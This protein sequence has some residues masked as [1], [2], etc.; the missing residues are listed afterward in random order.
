M[1]CAPEHA[2]FRR[3]RRFNTLSSDWRSARWRGG[4]YDAGRREPFK[5]AYG[6]LALPETTIIVT[7]SGSTSHTACE[8]SAGG[9]YIGRDFPGAV[10]IVPAKMKRA[11]HLRDGGFDWASVT[12]SNE[13]LESCTPGAGALSDLPAVHNQ[14]DPLISELVAMLHRHERQVGLD[15][16]LGE[17]VAHVLCRH[18]VKTYA[19]QP[20]ASCGQKN[21]LPGF[22]LRR[23]TN[24]IEDHLAE[25]IELASLANLA[26]LS[27]SHFSRSFKAATGTTPYA[28][29]TERR[30]ARARML[31]QE[32]TLPIGSVALECGFNNPSR[33]AEVFRRH[34]GLG[35]RDYAR[36]TNGF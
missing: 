35:P 25:R 8:D 19:M 18:L 10:S 26:G 28:Y 16:I 7:L 36:Q 29:V 3:A 5:D 6:E 34:V 20:L 22:M 2:N 4:A 33:F 15:P 12:L 17:S 24:Y 27:A 32:N 11:V 14:R 23:V 9:R 13:A 30:I 1:E 31:L 21:G